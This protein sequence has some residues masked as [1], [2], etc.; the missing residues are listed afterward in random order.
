M[1]RASEPRA[2]CE[3]SVLRLPRTLQ[4]GGR[5]QRRLGDWSE[6]KVHSC[7]TFP[8]FLSSYSP[9]PFLVEGIAACGFPSFREDRDLECGNPPSPGHGT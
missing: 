4:R 2:R 6:C 8:V 3:A 7:V 9:G 5:E 1:A